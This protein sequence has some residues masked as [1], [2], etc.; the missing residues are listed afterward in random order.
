[1]GDIRRLIKREDHVIEALLSVWES[2]VA[3][4][5]SFLSAKDIEE[6]RPDV[7]QALLHITFLYGYLEE[8][9]LLGFI[10]V[11]DEKIEML[12]VDAAARGKG[13]G[14]Q[15]LLF[16]AQNQHARFV[17][18]NEQNKQGLGFYRHMGF[19]ATGRSALDGQGRA[20]P[21]IHME[22]KDLI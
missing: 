21:L 7:K 13:A 6:I 5:H 15:L 17:D 2:A 11:E 4:T 12:F 3:E 8:E 14:K 16:A 22:K 9:R 1:M 19:E 10:G 18:V 20:F